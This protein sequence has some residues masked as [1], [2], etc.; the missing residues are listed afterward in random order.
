MHP[1]E[2]INLFRNNELIEGAEK[3]ELVEEGSTSDSADEPKC[4]DPPAQVLP[5]KLE[6]RTRS[7]SP[8]SIPHANVSEGL[9]AKYC[10]THNAA[11]AKQK[12]KDKSSVNTASEKPLVPTPTTDAPSSP[13]QVS[14]K[15]RYL[16]VFRNMFPDRR[17][18]SPSV[19]WDTFVQ[20]MSQAGFVAHHRGGSEVSFEPAEKSKWFKLGKILFHRPH[21]KSKIDPVI[22]QTIG[23][24]M[25]KWFGWGRDSF[26]LEV[27]EKK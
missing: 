4:E 7:F 2:H 8:T 3:F 20:A 26:A 18:S 25:G 23:K 22:L 9:P 14:V 6:Q 10:P 1:R 15:Q 12:R 24:R 11:T 27:T 19:E 5:T 17:Q 16:D 21:P 13:Q